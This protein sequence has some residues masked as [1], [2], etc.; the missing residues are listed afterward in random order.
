MKSF[1]LFATGMCGTACIA[2]IV[3]LLFMLLFWL[4]GVV[5]RVPGITDFVCMIIYGV[6][7]AICGGFLSRLTR[8][9]NR[10]AF[11]GG[12]FKASSI[13][14]IA[15]ILFSFIHFLTGS[16]QLVP[17]TTS[18]ISMLAYGL[19]LACGIG[20]LTRLKYSGQIGK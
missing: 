19:A 3:Y 20:Y 17:G 13:V 9:S 7:C 18:R 1:A 10:Y 15:Y 11:A 5:Q 16:E 6:G 12:F 2:C 4:T 14:C 8:T